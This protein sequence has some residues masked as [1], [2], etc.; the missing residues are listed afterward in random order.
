METLTPKISVT[1]IN[2]Q[3]HG[4]YV[5]FRMGICAEE[6]IP[7]SRADGARMNID[8]DERDIPIGVEVVSPTPI[9][10][11]TEGDESSGNDATALLLELFAFATQMATFHR[12]NQQA[13]GNAL[14]QDALESLQHLEADSLACT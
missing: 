11:C 3:L 7:F 14:I 6:T 1:R 4:V 9:P 10:M 8:V 5:T 13:R 2:G 12:A